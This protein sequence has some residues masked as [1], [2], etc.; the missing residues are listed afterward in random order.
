M[1]HKQS[2]AVSGNDSPMYAVEVSSSISDQPSPPLW[3]ELLPCQEFS[4][5]C[6][7]LVRGEVCVCWP[8]VLGSI[9][10]RYHGRLF[11][12]ANR[13]DCY[14]FA[15]RKQWDL[16][17]MSIWLVALCV[18]SRWKKM[19]E[20]KTEWVDK[21]YKNALQ[22]WVPLF[23][24]DKYWII[25]SKNLAFNSFDFFASF[26]LYLN[27]LRQYVSSFQ[28][29]C[30]P[31]KVPF[32]IIVYVCNISFEIWKVRRLSIVSSCS[33]VRTDVY[34]RRI[35]NFKNTNIAVIR[36]YGYIWN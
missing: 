31:S 28:N 10:S 23:Q 30:V 33:V 27:L 20:K 25:A 2:M 21:C 16:V 19:V 26:L 3:F 11:C 9:G 13:I 32:Q 8:L 7:W 35:D 36:K 1:H 29:V 17:V 4:P 34:N 12:V 24:L 14:W 5:R 15:G 18:T 6:F 22:C